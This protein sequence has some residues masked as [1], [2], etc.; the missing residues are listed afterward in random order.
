D[1]FAK[2]PERFAKFS[3]EYTSIDGPDVT[4]LL[5][6]SKNL[7]TQPVLDA[8]FSLVREAEVE[9]V[10]DQMFSG[11]HINTSEDRAVLHVALRNF[12]DFSIQENGVEQ[13]AGVLAHIKEFSE[14]VRSG[15]WKGYTGKAINTIVNIGI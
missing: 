3:R 15:A 6:Y 5:D 2:D 14:S 1:L 8:L 13:V 9:K 7:I 12:N 4:L 10:R 11:A